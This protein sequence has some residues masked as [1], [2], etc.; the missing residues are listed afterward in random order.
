MTILMINYEYPPIGGGGGVGF[1]AIAEFIA[2]KEKVHVITSCKKG[3]PRTETHG[4][5]T[6]HRVLVLNRKEKSTAT[7][8]SMLSFAP[9]G[10]LKGIKLCLKYK[11]RCIYSFFVVPSGSVG[12]VLSRLFGIRHVITVVGGDIYDP[13]K[14]SSPHNIAVVRWFVRLACNDADSCTAIS[15]NV[16]NMTHSLYHVKSEI[17]VLPLGLKLKPLKRKMPRD[18]LHMKKGTKY[19]VAIGRLVE[20][21]GFEHLISSLKYL[22]REKVGAVIIGEGPLRGKL[23]MQAKKEGVDVIF[24]GFIPDELLHQYLE[25]SDIYVLS[26]LHEGLGLV[27]IEAMF[28]GLPIIATANGGQVDLLADGANALFVKPEDAVD[29]SIK[30][31]KLV[32]N[33][34]LMARMKG[35]NKQKADCYL[36]KNIGPLYSEL[37]GCGAD[38]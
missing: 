26:S 7:M 33:P 14:K 17:K 9:T 11:P 19:L 20:R 25:N 10:I 16:K 23:E 28:H 38:E 1:K 37:L 3:L 6:V 27:L 4:N 34:S 21:K 35:N 24:T 30:V 8:I 36:L 18:R 15:H 12:I 13:T 22:K 31:K 29:I 5:L 2:K 32:N